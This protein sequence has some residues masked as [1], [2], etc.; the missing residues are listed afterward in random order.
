MRR[1]PEDNAALLLC[2]GW[3]L[4]VIGFFAL[5]LLARCHGGGL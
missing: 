5:G 1:D 3:L 4:T 2:L